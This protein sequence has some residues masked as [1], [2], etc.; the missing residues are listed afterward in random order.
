MNNLIKITLKDA[1]LLCQIKD[2]EYIRLVD[3][4]NKNNYI[5]KSK[6]YIF[7]HNIKNT[8][9]YYI[10]PHFA[11]NEYVS[12]EFGVDKE[13]IKINRGKNGLFNI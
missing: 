1:I 3:I 2:D 6:Q 4:N 12:M 13:I 11:N 8:I 7:R 9:V 10:R 5:Y